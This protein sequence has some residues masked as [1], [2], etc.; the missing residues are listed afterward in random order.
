MYFERENM[1]MLRANIHK[2]VLIFWMGGVG[3]MGAWTSPS[4]KQ[5][6]ESSAG[7]S[8]TDQINH[9]LPEGF[10]YL[11]D[12]D[13]TIRQDVRYAGKHNFVGRPIKG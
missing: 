7:P 8:A 2:L 10:V 9:Q 12:V 5:S 1:N 11:V 4:S 13:P 6:T 3:I